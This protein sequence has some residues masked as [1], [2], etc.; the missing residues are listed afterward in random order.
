LK[1][2]FD[3]VLRGRPNGPILLLLAKA[4]RTDRPEPTAKD[5]TEINAYQEKNCAALLFF[6]IRESRFCIFFKPKSLPHNLEE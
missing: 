2:K 4:I 6:I 3:V 5:P 1:F